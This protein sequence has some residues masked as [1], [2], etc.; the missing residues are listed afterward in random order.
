MGFSV[1]KWTGIFYTDL[2]GLRIDYTDFSVVVLDPFGSL[3][4]WLSRKKGRGTDH[5]AFSVISM[6]RKEIAIFF[7]PWSCRPSG[8]F[9]MA[10][11]EV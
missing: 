8:P 7:P 2:G 9:S 10:V 11:F 6:L 3:K 5:S 1:L 4:R